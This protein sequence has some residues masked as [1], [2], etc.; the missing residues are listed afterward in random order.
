MSFKSVWICAKE[1]AQLKPIDVF[2]K[3]IADVEIEK[4]PENLK[5]TH[6]YFRKSFEAKTG[7]RYTLNISADDFYKLYVNGRYPI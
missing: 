5:N 6:C 7:D 3:Q 4:T 1:F 2:H